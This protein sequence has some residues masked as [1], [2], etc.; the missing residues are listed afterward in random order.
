MS[1]PNAAANADPIAAAQPSPLWKTYLLI[2]LPMMATNLLQAASGTADGIYLGRMLGADALAAVSCF[3]PIFFVLLAVVIGLS[4]G[5]TVLIGQAWG[6]REPDKVHAVAGTALV[7]MLCA[8]L[9]IGVTGGIFAPQL[10]RALAT[11]SNIEAEA[12]A[13]ARVM[14]FGLPL[15]FALWLLTSMSRGV[16]DAISPLWALALTT[17]VALLCTPAFI[18]GWFGLPKLGVSSAAVSNLIACAIALAWM[19]SHWRKRAHPLAPNAQRLRQLRLDP[20]IAVAM[21]R[22][23]LPSMLQMLTMAAA[24]IVLLGLVN[25]HG[26]HATAA[27]GAVNQLMSW[28]QLPAMSV[29]ITATILASHAIGGGRASR[30]GAIVRTGLALNLAL[31]GACILAVY[32]LAPTVIGWFLVD[33]PVIEQALRLLR[34]VAWSVILLGLANVLTGVMRASGVVAVPTGLAMLAIVGMELPLAYWLDARIGLSGIWWAYATTF[35]VLL[36]LHSGYYLLVW[37]RRD[38]RTL[39]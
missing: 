36:M 21:L 24:E 22:I 2:L 23:G 31:T 5:A 6:A 11:P 13:Y 17:V 4:S 33:A 32:A 37:R 30:L 38:V 10:M 25:R 9:L 15:L 8:G 12:I 3:F 19:L 28:L 39:V 35:A 16:G 27:Y 14:L 7:L 34:I 20:R 18:R 26:S 1:L 29:G